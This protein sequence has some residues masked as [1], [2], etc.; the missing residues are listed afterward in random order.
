MNNLWRLPPDTYRHYPI[1]AACHTHDV[2]ARLLTD[3]L[4][5]SAGVLDLAAGSGAWLAR[6]GDLGFTDLHGIELDLERFLLPNVN[7]K[8]I[9]L[10]SHFSL[11][12]DRKFRI[13][14]AIE[15]IEHLDSPRNFL[16]EVANLLED[17]GYVLVTTPNIG[18]WSG[19][20]RFLMSGEHRYFLESD[21]D[22]QRHI[23][24][25]S[26]LHMQLMLRETGFSLIGT[27]R[28][29]TFFGPLKQLLFAPLS[30][31]FSAILG[32]STRGD[33]N[34]YLAKLAKANVTSPGK[35]SRYFAE[36]KGPARESSN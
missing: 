36:P 25:I 21:Y 7:P 3:H 22:Q 5:I 20:I 13:V 15:I 27:A 23:S 29:G 10:N 11:A 26:D 8:A 1:R 31:S 24:P 33:T 32:A 17:G 6:L 30:L 12:F 18:H 9:D 2:A 28:G 34:I 16:R 4:Q 14:T 35:T 19:R